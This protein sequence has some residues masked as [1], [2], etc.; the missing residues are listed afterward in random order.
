V[1]FPKAASSAMLI[2]NTNTFCDYS[3]LR[4]D[5]TQFG[6]VALK[7]DGTCLPNHLVSYPN[8]RCKTKSHTTPAL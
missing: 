5:V 8:E 7:A 3:F 1:S 2:W 4:R 6:R